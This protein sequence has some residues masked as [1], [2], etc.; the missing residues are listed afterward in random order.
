[1]CGDPAPHVQKKLTVSYSCG[2]TGPVKSASAMEN[3]L[4]NLSCE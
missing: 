3:D 4:I 1:M 2:K